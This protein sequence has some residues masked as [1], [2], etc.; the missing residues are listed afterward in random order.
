[1]INKLILGSALTASLLL[2]GCG[3]GDTTTDTLGTTTGYVVD[4]AVENMD[5][6]CV[7]DGISNKVTGTDGAFTCDDMS[8]VRF[9]IGK[10]IL[11]EIS[12]LPE[13]GYVFPQDIIGVSRA[14]LIDLKVTA[15]AQFLQ[16]C[17]EDENLTNGIVIPDVIRLVFEEVEFNAADLTV[18]LDQASTIINV[19][20]DEVSAKEHLRDTM[21]EHGIDT[22][23]YAI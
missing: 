14:N 23:G 10:L 7:A 4:S 3:G 21:E 17:D 11:G 9:R 20:V 1:M 6:D 19:I 16:S 5:Y 2:V 8:Q 18:Y 12:T 13:D 22:T 15:M